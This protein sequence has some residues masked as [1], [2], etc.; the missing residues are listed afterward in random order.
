MDAAGLPPD[1]GIVNYSGVAAARHFVLGF[2]LRRPSCAPAPHLSALRPGAQKEG[3]PPPRVEQ[4][5][6]AVAER[7]ATRGVAGRWR[8]SRWRWIRWRWS[9]WS[10]WTDAAGGGGGRWWRQNGRSAAASAHGQIRGRSGL[11]APVSDSL[12][13]WSGRRAVPRV[14]SDPPFTNAT[15]RNGHQTCRW[16]S[17]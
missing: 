4:V 7:A 16:A 8:Q 11:C 6:R 9:R 5:P 12:F 14:S 17:F 1:A 2:T 15:R 13:F 10:R 3:E